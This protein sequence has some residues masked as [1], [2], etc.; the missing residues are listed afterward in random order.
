[1]QLYECLSK[2]I[3]KEG[4]Q[5]ISVWRD[6]YV[7]DGITSG[8]C[9]LKVIIRESHIDT[10]ATTSH[11]RTQLSSL[12]TYMM[13]INSDIE[14]FNIY[15]KTLI[16]ELNA[17]GEVT[18]DLLTNLF[19]GYKSAKDRKFVEYIEKKEEKYEEGDDIDPQQL[20]TQAANKYKI[21]K[22]RNTWAA[23]SPEEEK[24]LALEA[25]IQ[26]MEKSTKGK[27]KNESKKKD[28]GKSDS[29]KSD[30]KGEGKRRS[31]PDWMV[32]EPDDKS[33]PKKVDGKE[34]W[35]CPNHASYVRHKPS[36]CKGIGFK[37]GKNA[38]NSERQKKNDSN[39]GKKQ[40]LAK[41]L[42]AIESDGNESE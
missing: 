38:G 26:K 11:I 3:S 27:G 34:Y 33:K 15:V 8:A 28:T 21:R 14:K 19:K 6:Q 12:D 39:S 37:P 31:K 30:K 4:R 35:W 17:R 7:I 24:I 29:N 22:L 41:A 42:E 20:M 32:K 18:Q 40:K 9:F 5:K 23:P 2:S 16:A 1:M 10:H 13:S 25:K 36:E